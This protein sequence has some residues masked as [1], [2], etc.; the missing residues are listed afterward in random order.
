MVST[1]CVKEP[2]LHFAAPAADGRLAADDVLGRQDR[3]HD[4]EKPSAGGLRQV[5]HAHLRHHQSLQVLGDISGD[6]QDGPGR[7]VDLVGDAGCKLAQH[8]HLLRLH[9]L[10]L[11]LVGA[12]VRLP[13][14]VDLLLDLGVPGLDAAGHGAEGLDELSYLVAGGPWQRY[15]EVAQL[16]LLGGAGQRHQGPQ[17][18]VRAE[19]Q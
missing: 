18:P 14:L 15:V 1:A 7:R 3:R 10:G 11:C 19:Q 17:Q 13:Q 5:R 9:Q 4:I 2:D 16:H 8:A 6:V 12:L